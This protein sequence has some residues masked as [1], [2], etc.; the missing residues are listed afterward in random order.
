MKIHKNMWWHWRKKKYIYINI[1]SKSFKN[2]GTSQCLEMTVTNKK[3]V[4][5]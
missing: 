2:V 4:Y 3:C 5:K 1:A